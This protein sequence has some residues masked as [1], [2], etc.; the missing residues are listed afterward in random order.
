MSIISSFAALSFVTYLLESW[1]HWVDMCFLGSRKSH[2][3][4]CHVCWSSV[5]TDWVL[6]TRRISFHLQRRIVFCPC[7]NVW[8]KTCMYDYVCIYD[9]AYAKQTAQQVYNPL[10]WCR[11]SQYF[12]VFGLLFCFPPLQLLKT[13]MACT[14]MRKM[15]RQYIFFAPNDLPLTNIGLCTT[16]GQEILATIAVLGDLSW[17]HNLAAYAVLTANFVASS[18][19]AF[20]MGIT[21]IKSFYMID[22]KVFWV[23]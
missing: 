12:F 2:I 19:L 23:Q 15:P 7:L 20:G 4:T 16:R 21:K 9:I 22:C 18:V 17:N 10:Y 11:L 13:A 5:R 6:C 14:I 8:V 3:S 1:T